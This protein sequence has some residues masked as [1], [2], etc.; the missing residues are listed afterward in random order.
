MLGRGDKKNA[1]KQERT[2]I[3]IAK[4]QQD[5]G[6]PAIEQ[7]DLI[8]VSSCAYRAG[9]GRNSKRGRCLAPTMRGPY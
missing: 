9:G 4:V 8:L 6:V 1:D 7:V 3:G 2:H 5:I